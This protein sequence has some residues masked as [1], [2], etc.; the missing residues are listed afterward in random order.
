MIYKV[1]NKDVY[2]NGCEGY[3]IDIDPTNEN[4]SIR[5]TVVKILFVRHSSSCLKHSEK[6]SRFNQRSVTDI[7]SYWLYR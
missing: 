1:I 6:T 3:I 2:H 7:L 4:S 5:D